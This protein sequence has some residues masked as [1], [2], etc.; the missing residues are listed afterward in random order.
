M[1]ATAA[2]DQPTMSEELQNNLP[3]SRR[4]NTERSNQP[5]PGKPTVGTT[6]RGALIADQTAP[7]R[8]TPIDQDYRHR[9]ACDPAGIPAVENAHRDPDDG[10][11]RA[12]LYPV[13][14]GPRADLRVAAREPIFANSCLN[15]SWTR[16]LAWQELAVARP[17]N[18]IR[19]GGAPS[20]LCVNI[21]D[22][23]VLPPGAHAMWVRG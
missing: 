16:A 23:P 10:R 21:R 17:A 9:P 4:R 15:S 1:T 6:I 18:G 2:T 5:T 12:Q 8:D 3:L 11:A 13:R 14:D 7:T 20:W 19:S 22:R